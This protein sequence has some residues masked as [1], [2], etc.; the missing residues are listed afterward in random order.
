VSALSCRGKLS[1]PLLLCVLGK[2]GSRGES[3]ML[4]QVWRQGARKKWPA[5]RSD[6]GRWGRKIAGTQFSVSKPKN[7]GVKYIATRNCA[8]KT[9]L[10]QSKE[11]RR[12]YGK[13][14]K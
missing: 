1:R 9:S 5:L 12:P 14:K 4:G 3:A 8:A 13:T 10:G 7:N 6:V 11:A 2:K